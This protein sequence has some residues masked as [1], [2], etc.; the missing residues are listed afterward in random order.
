MAAFDLPKWFRAEA[1]ALKVPL[2]DEA[3]SWELT[4]ACIAGL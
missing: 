3:E 2:D 4:R 1:F